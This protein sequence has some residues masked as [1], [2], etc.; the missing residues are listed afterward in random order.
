MS[1]AP[2]MQGI[3]NVAGA[4]TVNELENDQSVPEWAKAGAGLAAGVMAP[5]LAG[6]AWQGIGSTRLHPSIRSSVETALG[7]RTG[8]D[9]LTPPQIQAR[10]SAYEANSPMAAFLQAIPRLQ[11]P[12]EAAK[13]NY[14]FNGARNVVDNLPI[15]ASAR[16]GETLTPE[17][18]T[19]AGAINRVINNLDQA[20]AAPVNGIPGYRTDAAAA[21]DT[22][23]IEQLGKAAFAT[24]EGQ[25]FLRQNTNAANAFRSSIHQQTPGVE[26]EFAQ[27]ANAER[28]AIITP[29][30]QR[31]DAA[32]RS[33]ADQLSLIEA[34]TTEH[35]A[36]KLSD[37]N[38]VA[39]AEKS[40]ADLQAQI[41]ALEEAH[42]K[43]Q[44]EHN[45]PNR[46]LTMDRLSRIADKV[47]LRNMKKSAETYRGMLP[48]GPELERPANPQPVKQA[49]S[50]I[51]AADA[52]VPGGTAKPS[53]ELFN[54]MN[55]LEQRWG[56]E[57]DRSTTP[58]TKITKTIL[59]TETGPAEYSESALKRLEE[60]TKGLAMGAAGRT[61]KVANPAEL[62][63]TIQTPGGE[64]K[65]DVQREVV[66]LDDLLHST[67][68]KNY[69]QEL[70]NLNRDTAAAQLQR[71]KIVAKLDPEQ[72]TGRYPV[73]NI[74]APVVG[75]DNV[76]EGGNI[77]TAALKEVLTNTANSTQRE[78]YIKRL[79]DMGYDVS[80][81]KNPVEIMRRKTELTPSERL[82]FAEE[83]ND[84]VGAGRSAVEHAKIDADKLTPQLMDMWKPG[85]ITKEENSDFLVR[86]MGSAIPRN[87]H[88]A[89]TLPD[90]TPNK[91]FAD[92][93]DAAFVKK[94]Y[95]S[96]KLMDTLLASPESEIKSI[97]RAMN[98]AAPDMAR[99]RAKIDAGMVDKG[100]DLPTAVAEA[101]Q[102]IENARKQGVKPMDAL[103]QND[104]LETPHPLRNAIIEMMHTETGRQVGG[105]RLG[106]ALGEMAREAA[107]SE[108]TGLFGGNLG[109]TPEEILAKGKEYLA[110]PVEP[111]PG[112]AAPEAPVSAPSAE[113]PSMAKVVEPAAEPPAPE[114][115]AMQK[116]EEAGA[117]PGME[118]AVPPK[119]PTAVTLEEK[120]A[121][122]PFDVGTVDKL[123]KKMQY[124]IRTATRNSEGGNSELIRHY[125][126]L[127]QSLLDSVKGTP[128]G[129]KL[130]RAANYY[131]DEHAPVFRHGDAHELSESGVGGAGD[132]IQ[133]ADFIS[134]FLKNSNADEAR[135]LAAMGK[136]DRRFNGAV[137]AY[138]MRDMQGAVGASPKAAQVTEYLAKNS[139][140]L[141]AFPEARDA[142]IK[143]RDSLQGGES[144]LAERKTQLGQAEA[145]AKEKKS[146]KTQELEDTVKG[147]NNDV[148]EL[149]RVR[150]EA[151]TGLAAATAE[152]DAL[153]SVRIAN[154]SVSVG[155][156]LRNPDMARRAMSTARTPQ[157][158]EDL[159]NS[160]RD[161]LDRRYGRN[162]EGSVGM[163][164][165]VRNE[166]LKTSKAK[167]IEDLKDDNFLQSVREVMGDEHVRR[168]QMLRSAL[169]NEAGRRGLTVGSTPNSSTAPNRDAEKM[170]LEY[171]SNLPTGG[172][173]RVSRVAWRVLFG[174]DARKLPEAH[175]VLTDVVLNKDLLKGLLVARRDA[176]PSSRPADIKP[177]AKPIIRSINRTN[178][179]E[180]TRKLANE[181]E[182]EDR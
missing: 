90:G 80:G 172:A 89:Y 125:R 45:D 118:G 29:A 79:Q 5:A 177:L 35:A 62:T 143:F 57:P 131:A 104:F 141:S 30:Q 100:H 37:A 121:P 31:F 72:L 107:K 68:S 99:L 136:G 64:R 163:T 92:R 76:V 75:P 3:G 166:N 6:K 22:P 25:E 102:F 19:P 164:D 152:G 84:K 138:I 67:G 151:E 146:A 87:E 53:S 144:T 154:R 120:P 12:V 162:D 173:G 65:Y 16:P 4:L 178:I 127:R 175:R 11:N 18:A 126:T 49:M 41:A 42:A 110:K 134:H 88:A 39:A 117:L 176:L 128:E 149:R 60:Q 112:A 44:G 73:G 169:A 10:M 38:A 129:E 63:E 168:L 119:K 15:P 20:S 69:P 132:K 116:V 47:A 83:L 148:G 61:R 160:I 33:L 1:E 150:G 106:E 122:L 74:G 155:E 8:T 40:S 167:L 21:A 113:P 51:Y 142:I 98:D 161:H 133:P 95:S 78:A 108:T 86:F 179:L 181:N 123:L 124:E 153:P 174:D 156:V 93:L 9:A 114:A 101:A 147:L 55:D 54:V 115:P 56:I 66:E 158:L 103:K 109:L 52:S 96:S 159:R 81:M 59:P 23:S 14:A 48:S 46:Q 91:A 26:G 36:S 34:K 28:S 130:T 145:Q 111:V 180:K 71:N 58:K 165:E 7:N 94:A 170:F 135:Q 2:V 182:D 140:R 50:D 85:G 70:Q 32:A 24:P 137:K 97:G 157:Q 77:R 105:A 82:K 171:V 27:A 43:L 139:G 13:Q 17:Q